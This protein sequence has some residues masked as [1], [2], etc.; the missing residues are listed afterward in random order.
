MKRKYDIIRLD[1]TEDGAGFVSHSIII[2]NLRESSL[3]RLRLRELRRG[4]AETLV[5]SGSPS[6]RGTSRGLYSAPLCGCK[7][8][9]NS[10]PETFYSLPGDSPLPFDTDEMPFG[11]EL[12]LLYSG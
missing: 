3:R 6:T 1:Q 11:D 4:D 5:A 10:N 9:F 7:F 8:I 2:F 12:L